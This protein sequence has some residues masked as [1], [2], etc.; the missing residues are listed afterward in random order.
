M[1]RQI[2]EPLLVCIYCTYY[3]LTLHTIRA[4]YVPVNTCARDDPTAGHNLQPPSQ[5]MSFKIKHVSDGTKIITHT[6]KHRVYII[7]RNGQ[8]DR[9]CDTRVY[10]I[11][12]RLCKSLVPITLDEYI[13]T[14]YYECQNIYSV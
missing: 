9:F 12:E 1:L 5:Q 6:V 13:M 3:Y 7:Y 14:H 2:W 8:N 4:L 11:C 10:T